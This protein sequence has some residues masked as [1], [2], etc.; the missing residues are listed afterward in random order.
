MRRRFLLYALVAGC[1]GPATVSNGDHAGSDGGSAVDADAAIDVRGDEK[2]DAAVEAGPPPPG[3]TCADV[4][5]TNAVA[6][7]APDGKLVITG[8]NT[9][10]RTDFQTCRQLGAAPPLADVVYRYTAPATGGL[11]WSLEHLTPTFFL[12]DVRTSCADKASTLYCDD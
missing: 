1:S 7:V 6:T 10:A 11:I 4:V 9:A 5:D 8:T 2:G 3:D 12:A